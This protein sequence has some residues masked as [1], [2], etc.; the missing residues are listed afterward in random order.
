MATE[1]T[2]SLDHEQ[3]CDSSGP[4]LLSAMPSEDTPLD[5]PDRDTEEWH[6]RFR[7]FSGSECSDPIQDL[8]T[9]VELCHGW[10]RPDLH[11]KEQIMDMLVL[12]QFMI[13]MPQDLQVLVKENGV[14]S[15]R[16]LEEVLR[17]HRE[18]K[19]WT[20]VVL[21]GQKFLQQNSDV[22]MVKVETSDTNDVTD[23]S[24]QHQSSVSEIHP[25]ESQ[26]MNQTMQD[27]TRGARFNYSSQLVIHQRTHTGERP[28]QCES[29]K[30]G[31]MQASDL[32]VHQRI[33]TGEKPYTCEVCSHRFTHEASLVT[34]RRIH[35]NER[36][37]KCRHCGK[38][39]SHKGN[40]NV[41]Q[42]IHTD[43]KPYQCDTCGRAFRQ[44]GTFNRH[45]RIHL[46][47]ETQES[48]LGPQES[49]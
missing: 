49:Q 24:L 22:Q 5:G 13:S 2:F 31:F 38:C 28:Y 30:K 1:R 12:E 18:P 16:Q 36:P 37:Y 21:N 26:Q 42:R 23:F 40:L 9:L 17:S 10:L 33:H 43:T 14:R 7:A 25:E 15:C 32:R 41:H 3:P 20:V 6:I 4:Q 44:L 45:M 48:G 8:R 47:A 35:T 11:T 19:Q 46:K 27:P 29:C 34:H 39:F